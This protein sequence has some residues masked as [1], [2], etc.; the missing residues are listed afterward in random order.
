MT[1]FYS[2]YR[3]VGSFLRTGLRKNTILTKR[4][5]APRSVQ[6]LFAAC[7]LIVFVV[8]CLVPAVVPA[9]D[10]AITSAT[11]HVG[12]GEVVQGGTVGVSHGQIT[13]V[14]KNGKG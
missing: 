3:G 7:C 2:A 8:C 13:A 6:P 12:N 1:Y 5:A 11:V 4:C 9:A 14:G 10:L